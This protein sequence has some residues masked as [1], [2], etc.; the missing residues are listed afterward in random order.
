MLNLKEEMNSDHVLID[1]LINEEIFEEI[2]RLSI[3][4]SKETLN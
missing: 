1:S 4:S 2:K 3:S